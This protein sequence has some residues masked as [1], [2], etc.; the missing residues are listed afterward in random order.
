MLYLHDQEYSDCLQLLKTPSLYKWTTIFAKFEAKFEY[1][2]LK[3]FWN[4]DSDVNQED[5]SVDA[6]SVGQVLEGLMR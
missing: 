5:E 4:C 3:M 1:K 2:R 6:V